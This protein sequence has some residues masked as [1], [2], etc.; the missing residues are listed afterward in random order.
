[1]SE[2]GERQVRQADMGRL[3]ACIQVITL[4]YESTESKDPTD[5]GFIEFIV[6]V[7]A[8]LQKMLDELG[9][10]RGAAFLEKGDQQ[11]LLK[12]ADNLRDSEFLTICEKIGI[13]KSKAEMLK[14]FIYIPLNPTTGV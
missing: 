3:Q 11:T 5:E 7:E 4:F 1:M 10:T 14:D 9:V 12:I 13:E 8:V 2:L 6:G